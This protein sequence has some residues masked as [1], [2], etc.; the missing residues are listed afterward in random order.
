MVWG[1]KTLSQDLRERILSSYD[2]GEGTRE[3]IALRYCVSV[4]MVK[5]LLQQ[6]RRTGDIGNRHRYA[7]RK[8]TV[9]ASHR[10]RMRDL[11]RETPDLTL[12][13]IRAGVGLACSLTAI[14][15]AL[16]GMDL[17]RKKRLSGRASRT[18]G[19]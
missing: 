15:N 12:S 14:H 10:S 19:T 11:V 5:K 4:G 1:M 18:A 9:Q 17:S 3:A 2:A 8:P 13:E 6:R 7:G 16:E